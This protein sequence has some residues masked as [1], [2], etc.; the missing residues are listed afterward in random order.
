MAE[1]IAHFKKNMR[2]QMV[3]RRREMDPF[4]RDRVSELIVQ[5][6]L[7]SNA[8]KNAR[9]IMAYASM[10][11][12]VQL[13]TFFDR[14]FQDKKRIA[15]PL[16]N[17]SSIMRPVLLPSLDVLVEGAFGI[18]TVKEEDRIFLQPDAFD[19]VIVPGAAFDYQGHRLG[20]GA[21]YYDNF[22]GR[23][24]NALKVALAFDFQFVYQVPF[25]PH[26]V[27]I[28]AV[29]TESKIAAFYDWGMQLWIKRETPPW[30]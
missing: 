23:A 9:T 26:D 27:N 12:E 14:A 8:Y 10:A 16:L 15:I 18:L 25:E 1:E 4:E 19:C 11:E 28:D 21:G 24:H 5:R 3:K 29:I 30:L 2:K 7:D 6:F 20:L 13:K 22:L 17:E